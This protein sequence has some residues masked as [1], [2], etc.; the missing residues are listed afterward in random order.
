MK[1]RIKNF[2]KFLFYIEWIHGELSLR[3]I[4]ISL[5]SFNFGK[6]PDIKIFCL[7]KFALVLPI[8]WNSFN[9]KLCLFGN[10]LELFYWR[11]QE[12]WHLFYSRFGDIIKCIPEYKK[13][14]K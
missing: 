14:E 4:N 3:E 2:I 6:L 13:E 1:E 7:A 10:E 11:K 12:G 9:L 5:M 8:N